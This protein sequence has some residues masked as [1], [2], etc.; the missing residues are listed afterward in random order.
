MFFIALFLA[1]AALGVACGDDGGGRQLTL[2]EYFQQVDDLQD[3]A[4]DSIIGLEAPGDL[5]TTLEEQIEAEREFLQAIDSITQDYQKQLDNMDPPPEVQ[6]P[7]KE[8]SN[9]IRD[10]LEA[11]EDIPSRLADVESQSELEDLLKELRAGPEV[12]AASERFQQACQQLQTIADDNNIDV[13]M[14]CAD[15]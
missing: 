15:E 7:H 12:T 5:G 9:A 13:A 3:D 14:E 6:K 8:L 11:N 4:E 1:L 2:E 10:Y